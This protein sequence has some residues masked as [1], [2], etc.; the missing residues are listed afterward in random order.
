MLFV[1]NMDIRIV[2]LRSIAILLVVLGHS[3]ILYDPSWGLYHSD[4]AMPLFES[5][6]QHLINPI[7]MPIF[8]F[9]SGFLFYHS[10][11]SKKELS[12]GKFFRS[13]FFRLIIP[14]FCIAFLWMDPIKWIVH[15]PGYEHISDFKSV[16]LYQALFSGHLGH[17]WYLP[18]LF[19]VFAIAFLCELF[20][21]YFIRTSCHVNFHLILLGIF[22]LLH[23][24]SPYLPSWFCLSAIASYM[25]YFYGG[26][27]FNSLLISKISAPPPKIRGLVWLC[28]LASLACAI[29]IVSIRVF[30][31]LIFVVS[32]YLLLPVYTNRFIK[33]LSDNSY[34]IYLFHSPLIYITYTYFTNSSPWF[35]LF[36]NFI[37]MGGIA[38]LMTTIV[39]GTRLGF[40]IGGK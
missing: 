1:Y 31:V 12:F 36:L 21:K 40:I 7:Q 16:I 38:Y 13:K 34:G 4:V 15:A 39:A 23:Y 27:V 24:I 32:S 26:V 30:F 20:L 33:N 25:V 14:Y 9:I 10:I 11:S 37:V 28:W 18:T 29:C 35:V 19:G 8:F 22:F 3:I 6:K 17:L 2:N 5:I